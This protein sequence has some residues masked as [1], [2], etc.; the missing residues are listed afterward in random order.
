M[1]RGH[2]SDEVIVAPAGG[3]QV[4]R[5]ALLSAASWLAWAHGPAEDPRATFS[6][7][8]TAISVFVFLPVVMGAAICSV[9]AVPATLLSPIAVFAFAAGRP[10][11]LGGLLVDMLRIGCAVPPGYVRALRKIRSPLV[12]GLVTGSIAA[13]PLLWL[14]LVMRAPLTAS[15]G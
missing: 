8:V 1:G 13:A 6:M 4:V 3:A 11:G 5:F 2:L 14:T 15:T 9:V 10:S 12:W 7:L